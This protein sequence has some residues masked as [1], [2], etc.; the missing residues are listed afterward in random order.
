MQWQRHNLS[1]PKPNATIDNQYELVS[2]QDQSLVFTNQIPQQQQ[3]KSSSPNPV[4]RLHRLKP[5]DIALDCFLIAVCTPFLVLMGL[6]LRRDGRI[7]VESDWERIQQGM[8]ISVTA[9]PLVFSA[10][11]GTLVHRFAAWKL[12]RGSSIMT[13]EQLNGCS[14]LINT[15]H[16]LLSLHAANLLGLLLVLLWAV[17]PLGGQSSLYLLHTRPS[18]D[19]QLMP[20]TYFNSSM[21]NLDL[22]ASTMSSYFPFAS[23]LFMAS[24]LAPAYTKASPTDNWG[25]V[26]IPKFGALNESGWAEIDDDNNNNNNSYSSLLGIPI[27]GLNQATGGNI[28][29]PMNVS[30]FELSLLNSTG[31]AAP[32]GGAGF[33]VETNN[34]D[35]I[36]FHPVD[37]DYHAYFTLTRL[38]AESQVVCSSSCAIT[39]IRPS[40]SP[41]TSSY[42]ALTLT[43]SRPTFWIQNVLVTLNRVS[44]KRLSST[45]AY[46]INPSAAAVP[47]YTN[48]TIPL[49]DLIPRLA[50]LINTYA[51]SYYDP[52]G[53][54]RGSPL[55]E[56]M[57]N[58]TGVRT[59]FDGRRIYEIY[60]PWMGVFVAA[61]LIMLGCALLS[62]G[63]TP[64]TRNPDVLGNIPM[65][66]Y[67]AGFLILVPVCETIASFR[68]HKL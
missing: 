68:V 40:P 61:S 32:L 50:Q 17:S 48:S 51:L 65:S 9:F 55:P 23:S 52:A 30:Y 37:S 46:L 27:V 34:T 13:L 54:F 62:A 20:L 36:H 60:W 53:F 63:L 6:V 18:R 21:D 2:S 26:K 49:E 1:A 59:S 8:S 64:L 11:A 43:P 33:S 14:T 57:A 45:E 28:T 15:I 12:E 7:V 25:Y 29:F 24:I 4:V 56:L 19:T 16:T 5:A 58:A 41:D 31:A 22:G 67:R 47:D 42:N 38:F 35:A 44:A 10:V 66:L 39:A 3:E